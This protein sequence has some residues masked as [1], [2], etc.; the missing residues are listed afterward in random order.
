VSAV[1]DPAEVLRGVAVTLGLGPADLHRIA[2]QLD[3]PVVPTVA[4]FVPV[5]VERCG[6][7]CQVFMPATV[8]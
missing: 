2:E 8:A 1:T 5:A 4:E 3:A 6:C 7:V